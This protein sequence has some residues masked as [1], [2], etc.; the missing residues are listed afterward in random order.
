VL[1]Y[2]HLLKVDA[3]GTKNL[4]IKQLSM[5]KRKWTLVD[6]LLV[7]TKVDANDPQKRKRKKKKKKKNNH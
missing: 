7:S 2:Q 6:A 5:S 1:H 3:N 4:K